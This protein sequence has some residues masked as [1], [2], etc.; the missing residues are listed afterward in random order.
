MADLLTDLSAFQS[1]T[2]TGGDSQASLIARV[3]YEI[4]RMR[5]DAPE[6]LAPA[7]R[8]K[9]FLEILASWTWPYFYFSRFGPCGR[10]I[11][12]QYAMTTFARPKLVVVPDCIVTYD[13]FIASS[14]VS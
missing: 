13:T 12:M 5:L 2:C 9:T 10:A 11:E 7:S 1:P 8:Y 3:V 14:L 6:L 4:V